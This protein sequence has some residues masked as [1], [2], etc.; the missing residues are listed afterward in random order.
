MSDPQTLPCGHPQE[1]PPRAR[2]RLCERARLKRYNVGKYEQPEDW[3]SKLLNRWPSPIKQ[4]E[5][6]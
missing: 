4:E 5:G 2:C 1:E 6:K 3:R